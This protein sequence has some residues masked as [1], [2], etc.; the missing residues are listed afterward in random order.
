[1]PRVPI[2]AEQLQEVVGKVM[3]EIAKQAE[4]E[5]DHSFGSSHESLGILSEEMWE[6]TEAVTSNDRDDVR[7]E[8][9]DIAVAA[10]W[11]L[12]SEEAGG[13]DW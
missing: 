9:R 5:G 7:A 2:T 8:L 6:L 3:H 12:A 13:W 10:I 1:M 4:C 11:A